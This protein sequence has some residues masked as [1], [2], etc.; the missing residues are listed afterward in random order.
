MLRTSDHYLEAVTEVEVLEITKPTLVNLLTNDPHLGSALLW[1]ISRDE[2]VAVEHLVN[3]GRRTALA[4]TAHYLLELG[5]R[6]QLV[7]EGTSAGYKC[8]LTQYHL[9][10]KLGLTAIHLNRCL[11]QLREL[12]LLTFQKGTVTFLD[13]PGL[14]KLAEFDSTYLDQASGETSG[15]TAWSLP[16]TPTPSRCIEEA[17][18]WRNHLGMQP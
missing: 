18:S 16:A 2:A 10:D 9:A 12:H 1:A 4:R 14:M 17:R 13:L 8:P 6:L 11:R 15:G 7:G 5:Y 3:L